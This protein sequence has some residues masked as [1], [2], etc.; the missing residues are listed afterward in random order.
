[1][2][3]KQSQQTWVMENTIRDRLPE[4]YIK[5]VGKLCNDILSR[6]CLSDQFSITG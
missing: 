6:K 3:L 2:Q 4:K 5:T 1:M